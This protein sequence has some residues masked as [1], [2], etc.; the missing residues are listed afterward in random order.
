MDEEGSHSVSG[1]SSEGD[2]WPRLPLHRVHVIVN[3]AAGRHRAI[4]GTLNRAFLAANVDWDV[5]V[6]RPRIAV[7][8][9]VGTVLDEGIDALAV[10]GGD[11]T[12]VE[13]AGVL[14]GRDVPL[15]ILPG[16]TSNALAVSLNIPLGLREAVALLTG[17]EAARTRTIDLGQVN[18][19]NFLVAVGVGIPGAWAASTEREQKE[20]YG[21]LAYLANSLQAL[22][23]AQVS[24]YRLMLDGA[25]VVSSGVTCIIANSESFGLRGINLAP[26][27]HIDDGLLDV[28]VIGDTDIASIASLTASVLQREESSRA[29]LRPTAGFVADTGPSRRVASASPL[30]YWQAR[31]VYLTAEP[32]QAAQADGEVLEPGPIVAKVLHRALRVIVPA[33]RRPAEAWPLG[34]PGL[35]M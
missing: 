9:L 17:S 23:Q 21:T 13:A 26:T 32:P 35:P 3:P 25:E 30:Q 20:H 16:G 12:I 24:R 6:T 4:L 10:Y 18:G 19:R 8:D 14:A 33:P 34:R 31:E 29:P 15:A 5:S 27:I 28:I 2:V 22:G 1:V 7:R 11:G